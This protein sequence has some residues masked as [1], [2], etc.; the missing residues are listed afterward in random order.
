MVLSWI[1]V[2][3]L[4]VAMKILSSSFLLETPDQQLHK[5]KKQKKFVIAASLKNLAWRGH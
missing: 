1:G 3:N 4:L 2:I 5:L